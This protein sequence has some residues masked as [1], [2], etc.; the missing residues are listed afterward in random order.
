MASRDVRV[1]VRPSVVRV[2]ISETAV[3]T[4]VRVTAE[5]PQLYDPYA[6]PW[7]LNGFLFGANPFS[8]VEPPHGFRSPP[9]TGIILHSFDNLLLYAA[10]NSAN[11]SALT[12]VTS[13]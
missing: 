13:P 8:G 3:R 2:R 5:Q 1:R 6:H 4:V 7:R 9:K 10:N 11:L 12:L